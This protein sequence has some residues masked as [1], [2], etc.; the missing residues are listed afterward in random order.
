MSGACEAANVHS[1]VR[2]RVLLQLC[3]CV[4]VCV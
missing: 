1:F 2:V 3:V 4:C